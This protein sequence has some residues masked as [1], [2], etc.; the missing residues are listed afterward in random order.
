MRGQ[1][2][3]VN[4]AEELVELKL[5]IIFCWV[6]LFPPDIAEAQFTKGG[7]GDRAVCGDSYIVYLWWKH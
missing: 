3:R 4:A 7:N 2:G 1:G 6:V 5:A